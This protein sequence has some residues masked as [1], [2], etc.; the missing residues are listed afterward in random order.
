MA[1]Y[2]GTKHYGTIMGFRS[3]VV[4][5]GVILGPIISGATF[6]NYGSYQLAFFGFAIVNF[7]GFIMIIYSRP[8]KRSNA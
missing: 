4:T 1:D 7:I 3:I 5:F 2:F 8:P 6:D